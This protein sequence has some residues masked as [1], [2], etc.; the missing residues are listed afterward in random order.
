[1]VG[2][3]FTKM[4]LPP[5]TPDQALSVALQHQEAGRLAEAETI[6]RQVL[7]HQPKH[8]EALQMLGILSAQAGRPEVA[9]DLLRRVVALRPLSAEF[10]GNLGVALEAAG[11]VDEAI[12][13]HL[14]AVRLDSASAVAR[15]NL[16]NS[17]R[18]AGRS[19][20]AIAEYREAIRLD[21]GYIEARNKLGNVLNEA[22]RYEE[23]TVAYRE[24]ISCAPEHA[25]IWSNLGNAYQGC[26][27]RAEAISAYRQAILLKPG[28]ADASYNLGIALHANGDLSEAIA[29]FQRTILGC[30]RHIQARNALAIALLADGKL[31]TAIAAC[32]EALS[33]EPDSAVT[34]NNR[35][36]ALEAI[37][38]GSEA[39]SAYG[40]ALQIEPEYA[41]AHDNL[42]L[43]LIH[44]G[45]IDGAIAALQRAIELRPDFAR[46]HSNLGAAFTLAGRIEEAIACHDQAMS[47]K[48]DDPVSHSNRLFALHLHPDYDAGALLRDHRAWNERHARRL[49]S[50][51]RRHENDRSSDRR[52]RVGYV[53]GDFLHHVVGRN[54][55][56][57]LAAHDRECFEVFCYHNEVRGDSV[58]GEF[59]ALSDGWRTIA[60]VPDDRAEEVI[61]ADKIDVLVD[62]SLHG[63]N[64]R[65]SL[66]A[67]RPAPVQ[68]SFFGYSS[69]TGQDAIDY[70]LS[71][72]YLDPP[73]SDLSYYSEET[74]WLPRT[75]LCYQPDGRTPEL[76]P[77]P[78]SAVGSV[79]FCCRNGFS[80]VSPGAMELWIEILQATP[81]SR[82]L[83]YA[84]EGSCRQATL[85]KFETA[86]ISAS[87]LEF[88]GREPWEQF[89]RGYERADIAL[90]PFPYSGWITTCDALWMGVPVVSL[91]GRTAVG[92]GGRSILSNVGLPELVA[93]TPRQY[94]DIAVSLAGD[95]RRLSELR[96]GLRERMER[97][98]LRNPHALAR[99]VET[100]FRGM[101][102][103]WCTGSR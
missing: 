42:G 93:E 97:S 45:D 35:G 4:T 21:P 5:L 29:A 99:E 94:F 48:P 90:D 98:P 6:Y 41:D 43:A 39:I 56:P 63:P 59:R 58:T 79:T 30:P 70:R 19:D 57:L 22:A 37:G 81:N 10:H 31:E 101:W 9:V 34:H 76:S 66:F 47:L 28:Y 55:L 46:A 15:C 60:N 74:I 51:L 83:L 27:R 1:M 87:R 73:G 25:E 49:R 75:T 95:L 11:R 82:L 71:D 24:A 92:R 68:V 18:A 40:R 54:L 62:L 72:P 84:P 2:A 96:S 12:A 13:T 91:S 103:K 80:K 44:Q 53:S 100:A 26:E 88:V 7:A 16:G 14:E 23:A 36:Q 20:D 64:N 50:S 3:E 89:V 85:N 86:G 17:Y 61:R 69:T 102:R 32:D 65:A 67:R 33:L 8:P 38:R 78:A 77:L 52:L